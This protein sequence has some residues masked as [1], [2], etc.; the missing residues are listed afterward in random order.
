M[1]YLFLIIGNN[2]IFIVSVVY[3]N[4]DN[5]LSANPCFASPLDIPLL[6]VPLILPFLDNKSALHMSSKDI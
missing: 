2:S 4:I 5:R 3:P 1:T 6:I